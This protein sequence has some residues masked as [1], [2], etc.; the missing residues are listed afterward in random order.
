[1][2]HL[3]CGPRGPQTSSRV[4]IHHTTPHHTTPHHIKQQKLHD[5]VLDVS[6]LSVLTALSSGSTG[7]KLVQ[8]TEDPSPLQSSN[9][10]LGY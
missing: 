3:Q 10:F 9:L 5:C 2:S 8:W 4:S 7:S 6:M 1:M